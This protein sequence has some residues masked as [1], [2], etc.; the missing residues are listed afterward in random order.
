MNNK[1]LTPFVAT[2]P[3]ELLRDEMRERRLTQKQLAAKAGLATTV[4]SELV[5]A[6]RSM[7]EEIAESLEKALGIPVAMWMNLQTQYDNDNAAKDSQCEDVV[8]T[9]PIS[10]RNLLRDLSRKFGWVCML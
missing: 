4:I 8:V 7:T 3:G 5:R 10:D 2:H 1:D 9:I 6:R